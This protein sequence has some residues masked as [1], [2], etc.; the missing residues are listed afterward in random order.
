MINLFLKE[1]FPKFADD[2]AIQVNPLAS[3]IEVLLPNKDL[4]RDEIDTLLDLLPKLYDNY[5]L[6]INYVSTVEEARKWEKL[7]Q[8]V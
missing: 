4:Y 1:H 2:R 7:Y 6:S 8:M 5:C 3:L